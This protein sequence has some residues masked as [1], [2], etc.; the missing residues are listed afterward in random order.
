MVQN[1]TSDDGL[2]FPTMPDI[3]YETVNYDGVIVKDGSDYY[4]YSASYSENQANGVSIPYLFMSWAAENYINTSYSVKT[5]T[6]NM[7]DVTVSTFEE[8]V[9]DRLLVISQIIYDEKRIRGRS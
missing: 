1:T 8:G 5:A 3:P 6:S 2:V 9:D 7:L 4:S